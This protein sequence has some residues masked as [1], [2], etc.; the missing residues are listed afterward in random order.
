MIITADN[1]ESVTS[2][3]DLHWIPFLVLIG[4]YL[5][6]FSTK[7][8][9]H[10]NNILFVRHCKTTKHYISTSII[11]VRFWFVQCIWN[12]RTES[13]MSFVP[14]HSSHCTNTRIIL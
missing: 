10:I 13:K 4:L 7:V 11:N 1:T 9:S 5:H 12:P 14:M 3:F 8:T 2:I 6:H